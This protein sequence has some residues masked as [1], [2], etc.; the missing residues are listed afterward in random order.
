MRE[1]NKLS[2]LCFTVSPALAVNA[3]NILP[4]HCQ[5]LTIVR[6]LSAASK[7]CETVLKISISVGRKY[8]KL[9]L[10]FPV[11]KVI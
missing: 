1:L 2:S 8:L 9:M 5:T 11:E 7:F 10:H 4:Q 3:A 6:Q